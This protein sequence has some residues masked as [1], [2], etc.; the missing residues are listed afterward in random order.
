[1][2]S[3][4]LRPTMSTTTTVANSIREH[5]APATAVVASASAV[6]VSW[7]GHVEMGLSIFVL[8]LGGLAALPGAWRGI[9]WL[10]GKRRSEGE[11]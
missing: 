8:V 6:S 10:R 7:M 11:K 9:Q 1:M 3:R 5:V 2:T 4:T